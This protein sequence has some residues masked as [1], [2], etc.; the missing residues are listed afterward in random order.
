MKKV[1]PNTLKGSNSYQISPKGNYAFHRF[2][3][4]FTKPMNQLIS[5]PSHKS[6]KNEKSISEKFNLKLKSNSAL[7]FFQITTV[8]DV[9]MDG[10]IVKP[11]N[12][13]PKKKYPVLFYFYSEP[14]GTTV[15]DRYG[16]VSYTHLTLPTI[17]RV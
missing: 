3:N 14:A 17:L 15:L 8:D 7:S 9:T 11:K 12:M 2:S 6:I 5:L 13:D 16:A 10:W 4:Y 1:T